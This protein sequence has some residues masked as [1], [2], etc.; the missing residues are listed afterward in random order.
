MKKLLTIFFFLTAS[1]AA[2]G[3]SG[4][5]SITAIPSSTQIFWDSLP[6][7]VGYTNDMEGLFTDAQVAHLDS[8]ISLFEQQ[9]TAEIAIVTLDSTHTSEAKFDELAMHIFN[10]WGIGKKDKDN[11]MLISISRMHG[12]IRI[13]NGM[14]IEKMLSDAET[15]S[16]IDDYFIPYFKAGDY[17]GG[18][19]KGLLRLIDILK[20]KNDIHE[21]EK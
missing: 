10:T 13:T 3:Q 15:E 2:F 4:S 18:T 20:R 5:V 6:A 19:E 11:G 16:V 14:G 21:L 9:T 7:P 17:Y 1:F 12:R 8:I